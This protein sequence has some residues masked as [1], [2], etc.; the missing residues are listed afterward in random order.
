M[1]TGNITIGLIFTSVVYKV[2]LLYMYTE[3]CEA[4]F[5]LD[6]ENDCAVCPKDKYKSNSTEDRFAETCY[7]CPDDTRTLEPGATH[8]GLCEYGKENK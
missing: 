4:G 7:Q 3:Y 5:Y 6:D 2:K 8:V 1:A